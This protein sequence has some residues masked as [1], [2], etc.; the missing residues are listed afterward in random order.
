MFIGPWRDFRVYGFLYKKLFFTKN[1]QRPPL[2]GIY[3]TK[4][5]G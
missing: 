4:N 2:T 1:A 5:Y 3:F